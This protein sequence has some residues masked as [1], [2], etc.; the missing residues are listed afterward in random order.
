M[1]KLI[2]F[3]RFAQDVPDIECQSCPLCYERHDCPKVIYTHSNS[4]MQPNFCIKDAR[5]LKANYQIPLLLLVNGRRG[6]LL[7]YEVANRKV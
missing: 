7:K 3:P 2:N 4:T 5:R 6:T 1:M